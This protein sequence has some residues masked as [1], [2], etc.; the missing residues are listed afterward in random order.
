MNPRIKIGSIIGGIAAVALAGGSAY[1]ATAGSSTGLQSNGTIAACVNNSSHAIHA[2]TTSKC[3]SGYTEL[4]WN[5]KGV[6]GATGAKGATGA[7]GATGATGAVGATGPAG[8]A[9]PQGPAGQNGA[10]AILTVNASTAVSGRKDSGNHGDWA[11]DA[12]QRIAS[13]TRQHASTVSKCGTDAAECWFYTG[14]VTDSGSFLTLDGANSP[15]AGTAVNGHVAGTF[16]GGSSFE[17]YASSGAPNASLVPSTLAGNG[18]STSTWMRQ[19]F[20]AGTSFNSENEPVWSWSYA[21]PSTCE[22]WVDASNNGDGS[23]AHAG[24][25]QGINAC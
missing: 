16:T 22:R 6:A 7:V 23:G 3:P 10:S 4:D 5:Q 24:D 17:F 19:F 21:A 2:K 15:N 1:A 9:G 13:I 20:A 25:I 8:P 18:Q 14:T 12:Y 11:T